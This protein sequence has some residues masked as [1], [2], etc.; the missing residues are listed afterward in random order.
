MKQLTF[1]PFIN[2]NCRSD[3][4]F[5]TPFNIGLNNGSSTQCEL[6]A[7]VCCS[8]EESAQAVFK[9]LKELLDQP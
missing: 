6:A 5:H 7:F 2:G 9:A 1:C 4:I 3:C 8:D